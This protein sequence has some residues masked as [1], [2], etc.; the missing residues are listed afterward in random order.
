MVSRK[1]IKANIVEK[2]SHCHSVAI[3]VV[4]LEMCSCCFDGKGSQRLNAE[5]S[6]VWTSRLCSRKQAAY[7]KPKSDCRMLRVAIVPTV[8][9]GAKMSLHAV[10]ELLGPSL[11]AK[12]TSC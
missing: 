3:V 12:A 11:A 10:A 4:E 9:R 5:S 8:N 2:C 7:V 6:V 1:E